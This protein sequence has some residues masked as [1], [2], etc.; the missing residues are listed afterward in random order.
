MKILYLGPHKR[1][2]EFLQQNGDV[3]RQSTELL[4][5]ELLEGVDF[6]VSYG[7]RRKIP[8]EVTAKFKGRAINL[9]TGYLPY[10]RGADPNLW[11]FLEDTPKGVTIH[12]LD[13]NIDTGDI[14]VRQEV[15]YDI[16]NDTLRSTYRR[17][18]EAIENLFYQ[19]WPDI[20]E[21]NIDPVPQLSYHRVRDKDVY[22]HLLGKG[23]D[24]PIKEIL[25][26]AK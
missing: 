1:I 6:I 10:N 19:V 18:S 14:I 22:L 17:L 24:T 8:Q 5:D 2:V 11:S 12:C 13:G 20:R 25:G 23:W 21:G 15:P 9:H 16:E 7:Y 4:S 26:K 3:V